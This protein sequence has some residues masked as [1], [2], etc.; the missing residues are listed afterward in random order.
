MLR[1]VQVGDKVEFEAKGVG[2]GDEMQEQLTAAPRRLD[3]A[4]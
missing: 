1:E 2:Y 3:I 4:A